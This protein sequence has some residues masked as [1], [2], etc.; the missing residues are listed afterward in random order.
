MFRENFDAAPS[1]DFSASSP[2]A[3]TERIGSLSQNP[4]KA[5]DGFSSSGGSSNLGQNNVDECGISK[6][7]VRIVFEY[8]SC[9][10]PL[11]APN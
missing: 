4:H 7:V 2:K 6:G 3:T 1:H 8:S 9:S 5:L 10:N 11:S